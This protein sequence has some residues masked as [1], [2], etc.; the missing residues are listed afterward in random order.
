M[1]EVV[2]SFIAGKEPQAP[3]LEVNFT[4]D[5]ESFTTDS[6]HVVAK[7]NHPFLAKKGGSVDLGTFFYAIK[8]L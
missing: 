7:G 6:E 8:T 4:K 2:K 5:C 1:E 3:C